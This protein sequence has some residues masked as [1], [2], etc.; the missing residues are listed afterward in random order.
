MASGDHTS[1]RRFR[2]WSGHMTSRM[3]GRGANTTSWV[4]Q[5]TAAVILGQTLFFKFTGARESKYIFQ[6]PRH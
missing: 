4:F 2:D 5:L 1:Y 6:H 3:L